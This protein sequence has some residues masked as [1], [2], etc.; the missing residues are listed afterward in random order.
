LPPG[1]NFAS[2]ARNDRT[3]NMTERY[4]IRSTEQ[5]RKALSHLAIDLNETV[6]RLGGELMEMAVAIARAEFVSGKRKAKPKKKA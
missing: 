3:D 4:F 2:M 6:E 1:I 5:T